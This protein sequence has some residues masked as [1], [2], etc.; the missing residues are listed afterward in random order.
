MGALG[1]PLKRHLEFMELLCTA[2]LLVAYLYDNIVQRE[3]CMLWQDLRSM[4][5][6]LTNGI[7]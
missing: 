3:V 7:T 5:I 1:L 2:A 4:Y 6:D